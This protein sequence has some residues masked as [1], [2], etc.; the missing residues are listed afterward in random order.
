[1]AAAKANS[2]KSNLRN[3]KSPPNAS[4]QKSLR[5]RKGAP[6]KRGTTLSTVSI[7]AVGAA[8]IRERYPDAKA[9]TYLETR[10]FMD[11][12]FVSYS[13]KFPGETEEELSYIYFDNLDAEFKP[14]VCEMEDEFISLANDLKVRKSD[15][16]G[17][18]LVDYTFR[19]GG[20][21]VLIALLLT[22]MLGYAVVTGQQVDEKFWNLLLIVVGFYFGANSVSR[23]KS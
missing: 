5:G 2:T 8:I 10:D 20:A 3:R 13:Y 23:E 22:T 21:A 15:F 18:K 6:R 11:G 19:E 14:R 7:E 12:R 16:I 17:Q 1:M 4:R 9:I